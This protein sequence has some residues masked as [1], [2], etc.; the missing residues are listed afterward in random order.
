MKFNKT[1]LAA[2]IALV[3]IALGANSAKADAVKHTVTAG[4]TLSAISQKYFGDTS[5]ADELA[6]ANN[7]TNKHL[8]FVGDTLTITTD[9]ANQPTAQQQIE[10]QAAVEYQPTV[11]TSYGQIST[12]NGFTASSAKEAIAMTESG[13][14][15]TAQ[16]GQ[17]IGRYQLTSSYLG[18]DYSAANQ[19]KVADEYVAGRYGSW[20]AAWQFHQANGWY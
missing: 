10:T 15:Y 11:E 6:A 4:D 14:S 12:N 8:I 13:G 2:P 20:E 3:T 19:E 16:N 9:V 17:Y 7:L 5:H 18:G 1:L